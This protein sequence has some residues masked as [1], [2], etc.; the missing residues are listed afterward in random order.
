MPQSWIVLIPP[1]AVLLV[2][3]LTKRIK[4]ALL[5]GIFSAAYIATNFSFIS[6]FQLGLIRIWNETGIGDLLAWSE[7][8]R[9][10]YIFAFLLLLGIL[11]A[12]MTYSGGIPAYAAFLRRR[13]H[14]TDQAERAS[15]LLS[16]CFI[17][18]DYFNSLAVGSI[19]HPLTD[20]FRIPRIKLAFLIDAMSAPLCILVPITSWVAIVTMQ[21]ENGGI[22]TELS[23]NPLIISDPFQVYLYTIPY[24]FYSFIVMASAYFIVKKRISFGLMYHQETIAQN[25]GNLF[26]NKPPLKH[27]ISFPDNHRGSLWDFL[28]PT[29][30]LAGTVILML[31]YTGDASLFCGQ[32]SLLQ[33]ITHAD[34]FFS[35][36]MAS[37]LASVLT[38]GFLLIRKK[39]TMGQLPRIISEGIQLMFNTVLVLILAW[40]FSTL[41]KDDIQTGVYVAHKLMGTVHI[42]FAPVIFFLITAVTSLI[43]G[44]SWGTI[45]IMIPFAIPMLI[46]LLKVAIPTTI[47][48]VPSLLPSL[49][50]IISGAV[51]GDH[52]SMLSDTTLMSSV[53]SGSYHTD[54]IKAQFPYITAIGIATAT[55]FLI[56]GFLVPYHPIISVALSLG[57]G[58][59]ISFTLLTL[60]NNFGKN[61]PYGAS[62]KSSL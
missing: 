62:E 8:F 57:I 55:A 50:A 31:L 25:S 33:A 20:L 18:D 3:S 4:I 37:I 1:L 32:R 14:S 41:L 39:I 22:S 5:T 43:T 34:I 27:A 15:L 52:L 44:S 26:G 38:A 23:Q 28:F 17:I 35:L 36:F 54:H 58:M 7:Y 11:I 19:M 21:L 24:I 60:S 29:I 10:L 46:T 49:G 9:N 61:K 30:I 48:M 6:A 59:L 45:A 40:A 16:C 13:I 56:A 12:L 51:I 47:A 2:G 42:Q 53:S